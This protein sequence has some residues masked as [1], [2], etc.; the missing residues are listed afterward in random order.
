MTLCAV[1]HTLIHTTSMYIISS[2]LTNVHLLH[3]TSSYGYMTK[4]SLKSQRCSWAKD[5]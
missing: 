1:T 2:R 4:P 5:N 3:L